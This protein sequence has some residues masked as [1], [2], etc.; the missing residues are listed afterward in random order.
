MIERNGSGPIANV[1]VE[2]EVK[3]K[4]EVDGPGAAAVADTIVAEFDML[5]RVFF[6]GVDAEAV[7]DTWI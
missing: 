1:E 7:D 3:V 2:V 5:Q 4:V 6:L